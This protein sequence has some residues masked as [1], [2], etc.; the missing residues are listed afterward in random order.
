MGGVL[1]W[2][3]CMFGRKFCTCWVLSSLVVFLARKA[4]NTSQQYIEN[5]WPSKHFSN[6]RMLREILL[7]DLVLCCSI[8][9]THTGFLLQ[10]DDVWPCVWQRKHWI[11]S[12]WDSYF[13]K[14]ILIFS[15]NLI[16]FICVSVVPNANV[17]LYMRHLVWIGIS[18]QCMEFRSYHLIFSHI[19]VTGIRSSLWALRLMF[20][21]RWKYRNEVQYFLWCKW[22]WIP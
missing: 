17:T 18:T 20:F 7:Q 22:H 10:F 5:N 2:A 13:S 15:M 14:Y 12:L 1:C 16:W 3:L 8:H 21:W 19:L 11:V 9:L 6:W 4:S